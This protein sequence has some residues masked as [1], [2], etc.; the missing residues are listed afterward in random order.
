M[1]ATQLDHHSIRVTW[2]PPK[3]VNGRLLNYRVSLTPPQPPQ[4]FITRR[5]NFT[6][7][8][9]FQPGVVYTVYV[10]RTGRRWPALC[11]V[12]SAARRKL[13]W[14]VWLCNIG[15]EDSLRY[16]EGGLDVAVPPIPNCT[17]MLVLLQTL[18]GLVPVWFRQL[19]A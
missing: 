19:S 11:R 18:I 16:V 9:D 8:L 14:A 3:H 12:R 6:A 15:L 2:R 13:D 5:T 17:E 7:V 10:S 4:V 1:N